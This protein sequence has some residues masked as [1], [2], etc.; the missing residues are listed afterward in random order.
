MYTERNYQTKK[1]LRAA[2]ADRIR[3]GGMLVR[4]RPV[5]PFDRADYTGTAVI[6]GPQYPAP[7]RWYARVEVVGG[8]IVKVIG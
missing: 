8:V 3:H 4:V 5:G 7:H 6:E 2:V 1:E